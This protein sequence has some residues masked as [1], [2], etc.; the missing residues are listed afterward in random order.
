MSFDMSKLKK[1]SLNELEE[2]NITKL[3]EIAKFLKIP[4]YST[5]KSGGKKELAGK[6]H[7]NLSSHAS[8]VVGRPASP[9]GRP[10]SP[11]GRPGSPKPTAAEIRKDLVK[12]TVVDLKGLLKNVCGTQKPISKLKK[13]QLIDEIIDTCIDNYL[14]SKKPASPKPPK[15]ASP[16]PKPASPPPKP[17]SPPKSGKELTKDKLLEE[18]KKKRSITGLSSLT[19]GD[20]LKLLNNEYCD[21]NAERFCS[22]K[23]QICDTKYN[24]CSNP[25]DVILKGKRKIEEFNYKGHRIVGDSKLIE[26]LK[27]RL[28]GSGS[29]SSSASSP[30][31]IGREQPNGLPLPNFPIPAPRPPPVPAPRPPVPPPRPQNRPVPPPRITP[32]NA[33]HPQSPP[34]APGSPLNINPLS[35]PPSRVLESQ[36]RRIERCLGIGNGL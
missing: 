26:E 27:Q 10:A 32:Y 11:V 12:M 8:P 16:P 13:D 23:N 33:P 15:P 14:K 24:V 35:S 34:S 9:V 28:S 25:D 2:Y 3:K 5:F 20:L 4:G 7:T 18:L 19:K 29:G 21:Y 31:P 22:D 36:R 1:L 30:K 17:A 6:I